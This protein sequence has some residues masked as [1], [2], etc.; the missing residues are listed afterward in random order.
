MAIAWNEIKNRADAFVNEWRERI[1]RE[2][3]DA[4]TFE[5]DFLGI[6]GISRRNE[7]LFKKK[8]MN[9]LWPGHILI[10]M[11]SPDKN[12]DTS[13]QQIMDYKN[14]LPEKELPKGILMC[15]FIRFRYYDLEDNYRIHE[16]TL[17]ELPEKITLFSFLTGYW[18]GDLRDFDPVHIRALKKMRQLHDQLKKNSSDEHHIELYLIRILFCLFADDTGIFNRKC[19][20]N[21]IITRTNGDGSDLAMHLEW[22]FT[23]LDQPIEKRSKNSNEPLNQFPYLDSSLFKDCLEPV[24]FDVT[25][26]KIFLECCLLNWSK[27]NPEIFSALFQSIKNKEKRHRLGEHYT[28]EKNILKVIR[29]L[30]LDNLWAEFEKIKSSDADD[31]KQHRLLAFHDKLCRLQFLDPACGCGNFLVV[32]YRKLRL[33]EIEV[34]REYVSGEKNPD[35]EL[36]SRV[37]I[38]QFYG[39]EIEEFPVQI[40]QIALR[41]MDHLMNREVSKIFSKYYIRIP[42]T[43]PPVI[44]HGNALEI[45]WESVVPAQELAYILGNPPFVGSRLMNTD[46]KAALENIF[47]GVKGAGELDYVTCWYKKA[48]DYIQNTGIEVAF[49]STNSICQGLQASILWPE[50]IQKSGI[51]I[52]FA[53]QTFKWWNEAKE[54]AAVYCV[55]IGF[56][57]LECERSD[58]RLFHYTDNSGDPVETKVSRINSYLVDAETIFIERRNRPIC[59]IL[60]MNFGNMPADGGYLLLTS[61]EKEELLEKEPEALT[62]IRPFI[63]AQ[64]FLNKSERWCLWLVGIKPDELKK[65]TMIYHRVRE[66]KAVRETS[67]RPQLAEIPHL[68]AQITQ[69]AGQDFILIP[70][71]SSGNRK[72]I[73]MGFF[74]SDNIAA[75]SCHIIPNAGLYEFGILT[76]TMHMAWMRYICGR[77]GNGY[78]YSKDIIYNNFAWPDPDEKQKTEIEK[79]VQSILDTRN[80]F[81]DSRFADLYSPSTMPME[82]LKA[83]RNC[84][85]LVEKIYGR[86]FPGDG[87]RVAYL[88][89]LY[90]KK[91]GAIDTKKRSNSQNIIL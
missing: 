12:F 15:D 60:E 37:N 26:R 80:L 82:L 27:V 67:A 3:A 64:E 43:A 58:K 47:Y 69:P 72:Y 30:F 50:L 8:D 90:Q 68:F 16:F 20:F 2:E 38:Q 19:F 18:K 45:K 14:T 31:L 51:K 46:Q 35:I 77:L 53:H 85:A 23:I 21:Y 59:N 61:K 79:A 28:S 88:F 89:E 5:T 66:V 86:D 73:P 44:I 25:A 63:G 4:Q 78:R 48:A 91:V 52:N 7:A 13:F 83:H 71:T 17:E 55:I 11:K 32:S 33:L 6:F 10:E 57:R 36:L 65:L 1:T 84:D 76:S 39:I 41:L 42:P 9:L 81:P 34:L 62:W 87:E 49:V 22:I 56:S 70:S 29:P 24:V 40:A 75:N 54:K 74:T